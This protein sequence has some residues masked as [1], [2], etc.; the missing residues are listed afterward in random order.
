MM[1][2]LWRFELHFCHKY[3]FSKRSRIQIDINISDQ[4]RGERLRVDRVW[5]ECFVRKI[6]TQ[7]QLKLSSVIFA[8]FDKHNDSRW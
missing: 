2:R 5:L 4:T 1:Q 3:H 8:S 7:S 6:S